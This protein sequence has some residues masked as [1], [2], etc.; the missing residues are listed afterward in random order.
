MKK[1]TTVFAALMLVLSTLACSVNWKPESTPTPI[2]PTPTLTPTSTPTPTPTPLPPTPTPQPPTPT[3]E[4]E[5]P[6][7]EEVK[8]YLEETTKSLKLWNLGLSNISPLL[9]EMKADNSLLNDKEWSEKMISA[10]RAILIG[11]EHADSIEVPKGFED[12]HDYFLEASGEFRLFIEWLGTSLD[13]RDQNALD[14]AARHLKAG[15][16]ALKEYRT[17]MDELIEGRQSSNI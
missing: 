9:K 17:I 15:A 12:A 6:T 8:G 16:E 2:P 10:M 7:N 4:P 14:R 11:C 13:N 1:I 3:P 5:G